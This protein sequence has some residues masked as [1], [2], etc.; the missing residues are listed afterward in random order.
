MRYH[1]R[2]LQSFL[3]H[4]AFI[5]L[6]SSHALIILHDR[7]KSPSSLCSSSSSGFFSPQIVIYHNKLIVMHYTVQMIGNCPHE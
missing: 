5:L 1:E 4:L 7:T 3:V 6:I 2:V